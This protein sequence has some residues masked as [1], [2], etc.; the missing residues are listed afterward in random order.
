MRLL[1]EYLKEPLDSLEELTSL[2]DLRIKGS[3]EWLLKKKEFLLWQNDSARSPKYFWLKGKPAAGKSVI[4]AYVVR[5]L[6]SLNRSCSYF[7]FKDSDRSRSSASGLL[8]AIAYQM[9]NSNRSV[10]EKL[11]ELRQGGAQFN[12][13]NSSTIWQ[14][15]FVEGIL[16][17]SFHEPHY[18]VIDA[19]EECNDYENLALVLSKINSTANLRIL[20]T[21]RNLPEFGQLIHRLPGVCAQSIS[22]GDTESDIRLFLRTNRRDLPA[23]QEEE[24]DQLI[25]DLLSRSKGSFLWAYLVFR[26]LKAANTEED[27][28]RVMEELP[29]GMGS[30]YD[31]MVMTISNNT[32][33]KELAKAIL[34][35]T[36]CATRPLS[37]DELHEALRLDINKSI[38]RKQI[39]SLCRQLVTIDSNSMVHIVHSTAREFLIKQAFQSPSAKEFAVDLKKGHARVAQTCLRYLT[40]EEMKSPGFR[41]RHSTSKP[42]SAFAEYACTSF[43]EHLMGSGTAI[44]SLLDAVGVF[45]DGNVLSW[46]EFIATGQDLFPLTQA[47]KN[48]RTCLK[49]QACD[50]LPLTEV[51]QKLENWTTD[52]IHLVTRFGRNLLKAPSAIFFLVPPICP[53]ESAIFRAF[54]TRPG[55]L[56]IEGLAGRVWDDRLA[57][58]SYLND[59]P[60]TIACRDNRF[61]VGLQSG[62]IVLYDTTSCQELRRFR[63]GEGVRVLEFAASS[64][65]LASSGRKTVKIWRTKNGDQLYQFSVASEPLALAFDCNEE[66]EDVL[67]AA[68]KGH[69][70][71]PFKVAGG[72]PMESYDWH[73]PQQCHS[74]PGSIGPAPQVARFS[75]A[76]KMLAVE[77]RGQPIGL[78]D[79]VEKQWLGECRKGSGNSKVSAVNDIVFHPNP[80]AKLLAASYLDSELV[81]FNLDSGMP[82]NIA[83][84]VDAQVLAVSPDGRTL[85]G[86]NTESIQLFDF[87]TLKLMHMVRCDDV[88]KRLVFSSDGLRFYDIREEQCNIWEPSVL[89]RKDANDGFSESSFE[90]VAGSSTP[91]TKKATA[92][93]DVEPVVTAMVCDASGDVVFYGTECGDVYVR[94]ITTALEPTQLYRHARNIAVSHVVLSSNYVLASADVSGKV[95]VRQ[96]VHPGEKWSVRRALFEKEMDE[97][98]SKILLHDSGDMMMIVTR[99][100]KAILCRI[101]SKNAKETVFEI[102]GGEGTWSD[103]P[104]NHDQFLYTGKTASRVHEWATGREVP[105][106]SETP[107]NALKGLKLDPEAYLTDLGA[108]RLNYA[109]QSLEPHEPHISLESHPFVKELC[110]EQEVILGVHDGRLVF[111]DGDRWICTIDVKGLTTG[112]YKR[113]FFLPFDWLAPNRELLMQVTTRGDVLVAKG[114]EIA[115]IHRGLPFGE[116]FTWESH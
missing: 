4:A 101:A 84:K 30:L 50:D 106:Q 112:S 59:R 44:K 66:S 95:F 8:C 24:C 107:T 2:D 28:N 43:S 32:R 1:R 88:I 14:K 67:F 41:G 48:L 86:G 53:P 104:S 98:I 52:L 27:K 87:E 29:A 92:K 94:N 20:V 37:V 113:H 9:A 63:H 6:E 89:V 42:R 40:S 65:L 7:F 115:I 110:D 35:W 75:T 114:T 82:R 54:G 60:L 33:E 12:Y 78:W 73:D 10:R 111:L 103:D 83:K 102:T 74:Q 19:L 72:A 56:K 91:Q 68:T 90:S 5:H 49:Q 36:V 93:F 71:V 16:R 109:L 105:S 3:C 47:A 108:Q 79:L 77:C 61:A 31:R 18:W 46:I 96:C 26:E 81:V 17:A 116:T 34:T 55:G 97:P 100:H 38:I 23:E 21:S 13:E 70:I 85:A 62:S 57:C 76:L 51:K 39:P 69:R 45:L 11:L 22:S 80:D 25:E 58:T 64:S 99:S 15:V